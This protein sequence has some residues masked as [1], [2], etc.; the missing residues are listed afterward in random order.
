MA[1][2]TQDFQTAQAELK[3]GISPPSPHFGVLISPSSKAGKK[4][5][6]PIFQCGRILNNEII[7]GQVG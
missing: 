3:T 4:K 2:E 5:P 1:L 7:F 6:T